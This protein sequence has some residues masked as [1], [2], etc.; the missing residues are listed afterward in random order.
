ML[1]DRRWLRIEEQRIALPNGGEIR[2]FHRIEGPDWAAVLALTTDAEVVLVAQ[3]RH[4]AARVSRELPAGVIDAGETPLAAAQ[5]E[6]LEETGF[7]AKHWRPLSC[8]FTEPARHTT[9]AHFFFATGA[10]RQAEPR[11]DVT[12]SI[13]VQLVTLPALVEAIDDGSLF[14]GVHV[15][16]ICTALRRGW[17]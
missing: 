7:A 13:E 16:A 15:G 10:A 5:R 17:L 3:Y 12:E 9:R 4:G 11:G 8:V 1:L 6:L 14:H 2:E